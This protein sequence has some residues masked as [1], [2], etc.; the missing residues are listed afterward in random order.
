M[1]RRVMLLV[2]HIYAGARVDQ[3]RSDVCMAFQ[4]S[5]MQRR[6]TLLVD[7]IYFFSV[8]PKQPPHHRY[9]AFDDSQVQRRATILVDRIH[10]GA[11]FEQRPH[12]VSVAL[13]CSAMQRRATLR[14]ADVGIGALL[15]SVQQ[16]QAVGRLRGLEQLLLLRRAGRGVEFRAFSRLN[17]VKITLK[18]VLEVPL[19]VP[20]HLI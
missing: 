20:L 3:R 15:Q 6:A 19:E 16:P 4:C 14:V 18:E 8:I 11:R 5:E 17:L 7:L 10:A 12:D 9:V 1:Q 2:A 13:R